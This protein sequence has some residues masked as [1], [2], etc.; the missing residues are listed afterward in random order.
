MPPIVMLDVNPIVRLLTRDHPDHAARARVLFERATRGEFTLHLTEGVVVDVVYL[1][2]SPR[3]YNL[4]RAEIAALLERFFTLEGVRVP[5]KATYQRA[6]ALW[7]ATPQ[8]RDFTDALLVAQME[9][10]KIA[11]VASFDRD[12][13]RFPQITRLEP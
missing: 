13:D 9:R 12:F 10:L 7:V 5:Q 8:V 11:T 3:L 4:P 1:L 2:S 6:L